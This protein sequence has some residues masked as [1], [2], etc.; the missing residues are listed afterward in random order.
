MDYEVNCINKSHRDNPHEAIAR[1]GGLT[2]YGTQWSMT[3]DEVIS[4]I[5]SG[6]HRFY[7]RL[8]GILGATLPPVFLEVAVSIRGNKYVKTRADATGLN[9]LLRLP[10]C[11]SKS[12]AGLLANALLNIK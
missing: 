1:L 5:E 10:E 12:R 3:Q 6:L 11:P 2:S 8:P 7:V 9:N 4:A